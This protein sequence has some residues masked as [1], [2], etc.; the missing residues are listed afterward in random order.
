MNQHTAGGVQHVAT[1]YVTLAFRRLGH[2]AHQLRVDRFL[3]EVDNTGG[4]PIRLIRLF[5]LSDRTALRYCADEKT[6]TISSLTPPQGFI[7]HANP[8]SG[9]HY[10][11]QPVT[12]PARRTTDQ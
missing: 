12:P 11:A 8:I 4:D 3:D 2:T 5:G 1:G 6:M 9:N 7:A 10:T